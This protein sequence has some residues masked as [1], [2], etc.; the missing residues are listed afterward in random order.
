M[1]G[2]I[3][4]GEMSLLSTM[5]LMILIKSHAVIVCVYVLCVCVCVC[6]CVC[7]LCVCVCVCV[8][9][10]CCSSGLLLR[11]FQYWYDLDVIDE[12]AFFK[13]RE[14]ISQVYPG[15]E[16]ALFQVL[17]EVATI[18]ILTTAGTWKIIN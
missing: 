14:D 1:V 4:A 13:W 16:K 2:Y 15:K 17:E 5:H 3:T 18:V 9:V 12:D 11:L 10:C 7:M 6:V 8:C